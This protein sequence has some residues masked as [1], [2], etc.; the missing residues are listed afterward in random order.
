[1]NEL[2]PIVAGVLVGVCV[3]LLVL[4][5]RIRVAIVMILGVAFGMIA[6]LVSGE[7][8]MSPLFILVDTALVLLAE[9]RSENRQS[10][11]PQLRRATRCYEE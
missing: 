2:L 8:S 3:Q 10:N 6:S 9:Y 7:L 5:P 11:A 4:S 1:M